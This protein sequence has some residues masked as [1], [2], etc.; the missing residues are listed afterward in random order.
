VF[1]FDKNT[2]PYPAIFPHRRQSYLS[3]NMSITEFRQIAIAK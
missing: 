2:R 1:L 3:A